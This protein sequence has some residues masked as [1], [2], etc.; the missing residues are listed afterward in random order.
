MGSEEEAEL[1]RLHRI[2][3]RQAKVIT[4]V[5]LTLL[6]ITLGAITAMALQGHWASLGW[7]VLATVL[8]GANLLSQRVI[9]LLRQHVKTQRQHSGLTRQ[10]QVSET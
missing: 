3:D 7:P 2:G 5:M 8:I 9:W 4:G 1:D 6:G 10:R